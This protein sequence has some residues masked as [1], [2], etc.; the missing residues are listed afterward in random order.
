VNGWISES[1]AGWGART[2]RDTIIG[3]LPLYKIKVILK[4]VIVIAI[5]IVKLNTL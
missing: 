3:P 4:I 5:A 1:R 2:P